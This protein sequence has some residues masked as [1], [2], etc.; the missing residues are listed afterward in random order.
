MRIL[1]VEDEIKVSNELCEGLLAEGY[2]NSWLQIGEIGF[3]QARS[4]GFD[5]ILLKFMLPIP[6]RPTVLPMGIRGWEF[7]LTLRLRV[8]C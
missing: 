4:S 1:I 3:F 6:F 7:K 8:Y 2:E 5:L